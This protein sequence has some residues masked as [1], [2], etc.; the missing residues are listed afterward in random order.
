MKVFNVY[1]FDLQLS[2]NIFKNSWNIIC[3]VEEIVSIFATAFRE[4]F[5]C[6]GGSKRK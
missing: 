6:E 4:K 3:I 2:E 1:Y 5:P